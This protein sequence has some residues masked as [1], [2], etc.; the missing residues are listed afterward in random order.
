MSKDKKRAVTHWRFKNY[1][2]SVNVHHRLPKGHPLR[3]KYLTVVPEKLHMHFHALFPDPDPQV[4]CQMLNDVWGS[5]E[6]IFVARPIHVPLPHDQN[7]T[8]C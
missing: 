7:F 2:G 6:F 1:K 8:V 5:P 3:S 4:I